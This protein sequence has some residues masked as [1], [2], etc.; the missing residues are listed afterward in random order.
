MRR[1]VSLAMMALAG[2]T[3]GPNI[4]SGPLGGIQSRDILSEAHMPFDFD[5]LLFFFA[6]T[7]L[8]DVW[9]ALALPHKTVVH[10][11]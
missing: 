6:I 10:Y 11:T 1:E 8:L 2:K 3:S 5:F 4:G 9:C 7:L